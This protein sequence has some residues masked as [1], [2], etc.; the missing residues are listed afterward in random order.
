MDEATAVD[1][2]Q[3]SSDS[4]RESIKVLSRFRKK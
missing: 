3:I 2:V 1:K 4:V